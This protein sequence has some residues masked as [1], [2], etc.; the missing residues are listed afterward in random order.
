[1]PTIPFLGA[2]FHTAETRKMSHPVQKSDSE[3]QAVLNPGML[4][5]DDHIN[6]LL[7]YRRAIPHHPTERHRSAI[8]WRI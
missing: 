4:L 8:Q 7:M 3:W 5:L 1:M 6:T 2:L